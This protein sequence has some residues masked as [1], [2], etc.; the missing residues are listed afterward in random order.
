MATMPRVLDLV[1]G[2]PGTPVEV[3]ATPVTEFIIGLE[4][5]QFTEAV[6]TFEVG[7]DWLTG[8]E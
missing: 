2:T 6:H 5:F 3:T 4:T 8:R 1:G 7:P